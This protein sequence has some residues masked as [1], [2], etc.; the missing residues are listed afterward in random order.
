MVRIHVNIK[1]MTGHDYYDDTL[2]LSAETEN[3][4]LGNSTENGKKPF[5]G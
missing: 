3:L 1:H 5:N 4:L 2:K